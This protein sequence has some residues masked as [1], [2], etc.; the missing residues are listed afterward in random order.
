[1]TSTEMEDYFADASDRLLNGES[2]ERII[3]D[4]PTAVRQELEALL[5]VV[6]LADQVATMKPP[7][8]IP[9]TRITARLEFSK[10]IA[11]K[12]AE[13]EAVQ[14][15]LPPVVRPTARISRPSTGGIAEYWRKLAAAWSNLGAPAPVMR[16]APLT[17]LLI[18]LYLSTFTVVA[19]AQA[20]LP[21]DLAYPV[22][23]WIREQRVATAP[24]EQQAVERW[25][26]D[27]TLP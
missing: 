17:L 2:L 7:Q 21:G 16:F 22:K 25:R 5:A 23:S 27:H 13:L 12:R 15:A 20:A 6:E 3:A 26:A 9:V 18:A 14:T 1:M 19:T 24:A 10:R 4:Y 8:R 11:E